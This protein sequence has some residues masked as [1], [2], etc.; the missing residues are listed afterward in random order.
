MVKY[1]EKNMIENEINLIKLK[2]TAEQYEYDLKALNS[3][4]I[5]HIKASMEPSTSTYVY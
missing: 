5:L 4:E 1:Q 3:Q 2:P